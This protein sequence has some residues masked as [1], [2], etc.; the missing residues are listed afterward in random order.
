MQATFDVDAVL[1][2]VALVDFALSL[3]KQEEQMKRILVW[4]RSYYRR[5]L[6]WF[7][8][9]N[10]RAELARPRR[11]VVRG[12]DAKKAAQFLAWFRESSAQGAKMLDEAKPMNPSL[13]RAVRRVAQQLRVEIERWKTCGARFEEAALSSGANFFPLQ[14]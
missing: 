11:L 10:R 7:R 8:E 4:C 14:S 9:M 12:E 5:A 13:S 3:A 1:T 6:I 2:S